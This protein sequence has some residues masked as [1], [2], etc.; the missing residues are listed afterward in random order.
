MSNTT[1]IVGKA[2]VGKSTFLNEVVGATVTKESAAMHSDG[3]AKA[4]SILHGGERFID[5]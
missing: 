1:L 2:G 3:T 5:T 4:T